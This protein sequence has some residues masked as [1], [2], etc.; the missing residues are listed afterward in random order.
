MD[1]HIMVVDMSESDLGTLVFMRCLE[2]DPAFES[3]R[4]VLVTSEAQDLKEMTG[5][6]VATSIKRPFTETQL[7]SVVDAIIR[8]NGFHRRHT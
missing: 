3:V 4:M 7:L 8:A 6:A 1:A 2:N 5:G